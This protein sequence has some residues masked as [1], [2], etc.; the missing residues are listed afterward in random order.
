[1][2]GLLLTCEPICFPFSGVVS[3][4]LAV[5][6]DFTVNCRHYWYEQKLACLLWK[7]DSKEIIMSRTSSEYT[8]N[9]LRSTINVRSFLPASSPHPSPLLL[10]ACRDHDS[11]STSDSSSFRSDHMLLNRESLF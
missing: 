10:P 9:N 7:V 6:H 3:C 4:F 8:L 1:M 2:K 5:D 11:C